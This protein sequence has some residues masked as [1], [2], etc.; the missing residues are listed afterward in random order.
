VLA[1]CIGLMA[2]TAEFVGPCHSALLHNRN[3]YKSSKMVKSI[4]FVRDP[5]GI[6]VEYAHTI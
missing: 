1:I 6:K 3:A 4:E 2:A 5:S